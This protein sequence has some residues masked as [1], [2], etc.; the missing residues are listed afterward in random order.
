MVVVSLSG[1]DKYGYR[2]NGDNQIM[3]FNR[4]YQRMVKY[5]LTEKKTIW[6]EY[7]D[8]LY[9]YE[10]TTENNIYTIGHSY[11][12]NFKIIDMNDHGTTTLLKLGGEEAIFPLATDNE[13]YYFV[14]CY[15]DKKGV[16]FKDKRRIAMFDMESKKLKDIETTGGLILYGTILGDKLY[17]TVY[18]E[19]NELYDLFELEYN[20][21][22]ASPKKIKSGINGGKV[23]N[24]GEEL[25]IV[26]NEY[27]VSQNNGR[28]IKA[29][30]LN[31]F[32][33]DAIV[34][35][36]M[37]E[38]CIVILQII[39]K[40]TGDVKYEKDGIYDFKVMGNKMTVY[41]EGFIDEVEF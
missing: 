20:S 7:R 23:Y 10:F 32:I 1:C 22:T 3:L 17:Y 37:S 16:E 14:H 18:D 5:D 25:W 2:V 19:D 30:S 21:L 31:Y 13:V 40:V 33:N 9:Q 6:S 11:E 29:A 12:N 36:D 35:I 27:L 39:D 15:H 4:F 38:N 8:N 24:D 28:E 34:Q 41:G 26:H